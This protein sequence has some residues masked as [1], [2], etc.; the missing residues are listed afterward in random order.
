MKIKIFVL[1]FAALLG[2][3]AEAGD[4]ATLTVACYEGIEPIIQDAI[5]GWLKKHPDVDIKV[6]SREFND[7]HP[8]LIRALAS[9]T[10]LPDVMALEVGNISR[11]VE[12]G[13]VEDLAPPPYDAARFRSKFIPYALAQATTDTGVIGALPTNVG[14][15]TLFYRKDIIDRAGVTEADLTRSW[16]SYI[17]AGTKIRQKTGAALVGNASDIKEVMIRIGLQSGEGIY[18][19]K[20]HKVLIDGPRFVRALTM[21]KLVRERKLDA[22]LVKWDAVWAEALKR[23]KF[24]TMLTGAWFGGQMADRWATE[25]RGLWRAAPLPGGALAPF[26]GSFYA[27]PKKSAQKDLAWEFVQYMTLD[28]EQQL[29]AFKNYDAFPA[30]LA[31]QDDPFYAQP[32]AFLGDQKARLLWRDIANRIPAIAVDRDDQLAADT[33]VAALNEVLNQDKDPKEV[34]I[35]SKKYLE[36]LVWSRRAH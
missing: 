30:L 19:D 12:T 35:R 16:D 34:L 25:T 11:F 15:G 2:G 1:A 32:V 5:P 27:I 17:E 31:A 22:D 14:P 18:F 28:K 9:G 24:A 26:G 3:L 6:V 10:G 36:R 4:K 8:A 13:G 20:S 23:G 29:R 7:H 33:V 21:S